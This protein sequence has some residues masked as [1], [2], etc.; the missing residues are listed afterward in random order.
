MRTRRIIHLLRG[1][2]TQ[3][4]RQFCGRRVSKCDHF[5]T[6][7][8]E[9]AG[10]SG[11]ATREWVCL[12][13]LSLSIHLGLGRK[14]VGEGESS[15]N[16]KDAIILLRKKLIQ[17]LEK[18]E[19]LVKISSQRCEVRRVG[20]LLNWGLCG[21]TYLLQWESPSRVLC[22]DRQPNF[23]FFFFFFLILIYLATPCLCCDMQDL[24][25]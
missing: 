3:A 6:C 25:F 8:E 4:L 23:F 11:G 22:L 19:H 10:P 16:H 17:K 13:W 1:K 7:Q 15:W 24:P 14:G 20:S 5:V 21:P 12:M 18:T 2:W 9:R